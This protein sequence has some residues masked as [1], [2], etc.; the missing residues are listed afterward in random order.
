VPLQNKG[1]KRLF[2]QPVKSCPDTRTIA[3]KF[4]RKL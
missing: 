4:F 2:Q 3:G 1:H